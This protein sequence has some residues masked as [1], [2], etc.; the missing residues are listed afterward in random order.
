MATKTINNV[1]KTKKRVSKN[2]TAGQ[3]HIKTSTPS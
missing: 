3:V 1:K 2:V